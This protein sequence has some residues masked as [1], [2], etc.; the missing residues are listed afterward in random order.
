M[1]AKVKPTVLAAPSGIG[2]QPAQ[3]HRLQSITYAAG[4]IGIDSNP[5]VINAERAKAS[6][7][8]S[9]ICKTTLPFIIFA[10]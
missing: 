7:F 10:S 3:Y 1:A 6:L 8:V 2:S 5:L 4:R 9:F